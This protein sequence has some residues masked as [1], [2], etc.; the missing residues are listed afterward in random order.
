MAKVSFET[1]GAIHSLVFPVP[2]DDQVLQEKGKTPAMQRSHTFLIPKRDG[3]SR[4]ILRHRSTSWTGKIET[5]SYGSLSY[6]FR[7]Q[8][9][10]W[11]IAPVQLPL[12]GNFVWPDRGFSISVWFQI[13][14]RKFGAFIS[15]DRKPMSGPFMERR[16][17]RRRMNSGASDGISGSTM[18]SDA[19]LFHLASF[20]SINALFEI[21]VGSR[22]GQLEYR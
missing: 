12:K 17:S 2:I 15:R 11:E 14:D 19:V 5:S 4:S 10:A 8:A 1:W 21:W 20:G 18:S 13:Q 22:P 7:S 3:Q 9:C 6:G 16:R